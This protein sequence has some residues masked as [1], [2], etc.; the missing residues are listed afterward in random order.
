MSRA[1]VSRI[2]KCQDT[3]GKFISYRRHESTISIQI[4]TTTLVRNLS[5]CMLETVH[6]CSS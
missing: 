3:H 5:I 6:D 1:N 2:F 4:K